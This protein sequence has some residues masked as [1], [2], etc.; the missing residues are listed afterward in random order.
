MLSIM[1]SWLK[2][3]IV[4]VAGTNDITG[5]KTGWPGPSPAP[6][7]KEPG[8]TPAGRLFGFGELN[9]GECGTWRPLW[10]TMNLTGPF[11]VDEGK[12]GA[13]G[14][15]PETIVPAA[16]ML[17]SNRS[18]A[19]GGV[20]GGPVQDVATPRGTGG[21]PI[22]APVWTYLLTAPTT[23]SAGTTLSVLAGSS[24]S[25][26]SSSPAAAVR[27]GV[28]RGLKLQPNASNCE[29]SHPLPLP[30]SLV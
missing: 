2:Y 3:R 29:C 11:L 18:T 26:S 27:V 5:S 4:A 14:A 6:Y 13:D 28:A 30:A 17:C 23:D 9:G 16:H 7:L 1:V 15:A 21:E 24:S 10:D 8:A 12:G 25:M 19:D 20:H 22:Y